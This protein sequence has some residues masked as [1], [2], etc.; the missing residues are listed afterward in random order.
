MAAPAAA[1]AAAA[2]SC[3]DTWDEIPPLLADE[4][5]VWSAWPCAA[6]AP[7][8]PVALMDLLPGIRGV[9]PRGSDDDKTELAVEPSA[10]CALLLLPGRPDATA[11]AEGPAPNPDAEAITAA[12]EDAPF[13]TAAAAAGYP[14]V[15]DDGPVATPLMRP[16]RS[17]RP[18][19]PRCPD[20]GP[21][22]PSSVSPSSSGLWTWFWSAAREA[23]LACHRDGCGSVGLGGSG[24]VAG[25]LPGMADVMVT[26]AGELAA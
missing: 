12:E 5:G 14:A 9:P 1:A 4:A 25:E 22:L 18:A 19:P 24:V 13:I 10:A 2:A 6:C 8:L 11:A 3:L 20:E 26:A 17:F 23:L 21:P 15:L 7:L 16:M